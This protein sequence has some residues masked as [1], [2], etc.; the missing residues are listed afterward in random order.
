MPR[1]KSTGTP[2]DDALAADA[3]PPQVSE[4]AENPAATAFIE[5]WSKAGASERANSQSFI[6][7]LTKLLEVAPP[8]HSHED[9]YSFEYPVRIN[10]GLAETTGFVDLYKRGCFVLEAKQFV[11]QKE[12]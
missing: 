4:K 1:S 11:A 8:S 9:G 3:V 12:E 5:Y 7:G 10:T 6:I 2:P